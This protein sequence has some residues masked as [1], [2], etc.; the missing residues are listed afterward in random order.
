[1]KWLRSIKIGSTT[2]ITTKSLQNP[3]QQPTTNKNNINI[4]NINR[5]NINRNKTME[6]MAPTAINEATIPK[7]GGGTTTPEKALGLHPVE[8]ITP[9]AVN[10]IAKVASGDQRPGCVTRGRGIRPG[11]G[12]AEGRGETSTRWTTQWDKKMGGFGRG[13]SKAASV[14]KGASASAGQ[15][16]KK[17]FFSRTKP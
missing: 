9:K 16:S 13:S 15:R 2:G 7:T 10:N 4:N 11:R 17:A 3:T 14:K 8:D 12:G 6:T 5:N 1:M